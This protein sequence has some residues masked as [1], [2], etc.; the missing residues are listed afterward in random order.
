MT[1]Q[2]LFGETFQILEDGQKWSYIKI[3]FD[4]YEGWIDNNSISL[5]ER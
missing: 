3:T 5:F 4:N 2:L 1:T